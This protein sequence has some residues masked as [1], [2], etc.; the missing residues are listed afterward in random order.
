MY[1]LSRALASVIPCLLSS[2]APHGARRTA[3]P[4]RMDMHGRFFA[5]GNGAIRLRSQVSAKPVAPIQ[6]HCTFDPQGSTVRI[7]YVQYFS[8]FLKTL[9]THT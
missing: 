7:T 9:Q 8:F 5:L 1:S 4:S 2:G 3:M 6:S